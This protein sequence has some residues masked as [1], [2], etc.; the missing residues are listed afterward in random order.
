MSP[1]PSF[2]RAQ[3]RRTG[4]INSRSRHSQGQLNWALVLL[5][6]G[7]LLGIGAATVLLGRRDRLQ[8]DD[9]DAP[10]FI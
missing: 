6:V 3:A 5:G 8:P 2:K 10:L 4:S 7:A 9:P 1:R